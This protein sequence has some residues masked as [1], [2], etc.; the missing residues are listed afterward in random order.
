MGGVSNSLVML[1]LAAWF[2]AAASS[3]GQSGFLT[4]GLYA[5][6]P[7]HAGV[8]DESPAGTNALAVRTLWAADRRASIDSRSVY[9]RRVVSTNADDVL[10]N[11]AALVFGGP[12]LGEPTAT[13]FRYGHRY[14]LS[15]WLKP[16]LDCQGI[17]YLAA[18]LGQ[19]SIRRETNGW[20]ISWTLGLKAEVSPNSVEWYVPQ[21]DISAAEFASLAKAAGAAGPWHHLVLVEDKAGSILDRA[22]PGSMS[23]YV[24]GRLAK[25]AQFTVH[26]ASLARYRPLEFALGCQ[27]GWTAPPLPPSPPEDRSVYTRPP[28]YSGLIDD[29]R[30]YSRPLTAA[31]VRALYDVERIPVA[32]AR[33][34]PGAA[35]GWLRLVTGIRPGSTFRFETSTDLL[36]WVVQEPETY[37][38]PEGL[39][40]EFPVGGPRGFF[41]LREV[42]ESVVDL[43]VIAREPEPVVR[44]IGQPVTLSAAAVGEEPLRYRWLRDGVPVVGG[45]GPSLQIPSVDRLHAGSYSL[46]VSN[47]FGLAQ[48]RSVQ[49][50]VGLPPSIRSGPTDVTLLFPVNSGDLDRRYFYLPPEYKVGRTNSLQ[51]SVTGDPPLSHFWRGDGI[52]TTAGGPDLLVKVDRGPF[53]TSPS[54]I[55]PTELPIGGPSFFQAIV[56]NLFGRATSQ[57]ATVRILGAPR[58][59]G[60]A[61]AELKLPVSGSVRI[62]V[63][64]DGT[65]TFLCRWFRDGVNVSEPGPFE[66]LKPGE[67]SLQVS[68]PGNY[69]FQAAN[70]YGWI[71]SRFIKVIR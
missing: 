70:D 69:Q 2:V 37:A 25:T 52:L 6:Y 5:H 43:P 13:S 28:G 64:F 61:P 50:Q 12:P 35:P 38:G 21:L 1:L 31:E 30:V 27:A 46:V 41:R 11:L 49:L 18:E 42:R 15:A 14:S 39:D 32:S 26:R 59:T 36:K 63:R 68:V 7:F 3:R 66:V 24:D 17:W 23:L 55:V 62:W 20:S 34:L 29:V 22:L 44:A 58:I 16:D 53:A 19:S 33:L 47:R 40:L 10:T 45:S 67:I 60:E 57:V 51:V 56:T 65:P 71:R 48:T 8:R 54:G 4:N 9:F